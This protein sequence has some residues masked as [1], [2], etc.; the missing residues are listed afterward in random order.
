MAIVFQKPEKGPV[1]CGATAR[2]G[3]VVGK[4]EEDLG[5][6]MVGGR[7][8]ADAVEGGFGGAAAAA[9]PGPEAIVPIGAVGGKTLL[10]VARNS[11]LLVSPAA[12]KTRKWSI[13]NV[14]PVR[15]S[16]T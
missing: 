9:K 16:I 11:I 4:V 13:P 7:D 10:C 6:A 8:A 3:A 2:V 12:A 15:C 14:K 5:G 1:F